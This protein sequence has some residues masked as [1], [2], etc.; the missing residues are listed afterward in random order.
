MMNQTSKTKQKMFQSLSKSI[1]KSFASKSRLRRTLKKL[2]R[3][4]QKIQ[5][6]TKLRRTRNKRSGSTEFVSK[7]KNARQPLSL[8]IA[9]KLSS[10]TQSKNTQPPQLKTL[11]TSQSKL[12]TSK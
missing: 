7:K 11:K 10:K 2:R 1:L 4:L 9:S 5:R 8:L 12:K 3:T 6:I